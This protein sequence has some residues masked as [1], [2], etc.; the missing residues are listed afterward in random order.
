[1]LLTVGLGLLLT[2]LDQ[3]RLGTLLVGVALLAGSLMRWLVPHVGM[4]AV[5]SRFTDIVTYGGWGR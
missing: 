4:L 5:R 2:A 1:M 3:F